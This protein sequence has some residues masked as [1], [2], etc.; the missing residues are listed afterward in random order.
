MKKLMS[1]LIA[2]LLI[3]GNNVT[4]FA[5]EDT[6]VD[7]NI[8]A[9]SNIKLSAEKAKFSVTVPISM[10]LLVKSEGNV[11]GGS[12][13]I[14]N[15]SA[16]PVKVTNVKVISQPGW[17]LVAGDADLRASYINSKKIG[18]KVNGANCDEN[19]DFKIEQINFPVINVDGTNE[20]NWG[21]IATSFEEIQ[22]E[23]TVATVVYTIGFAK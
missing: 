2:M 18:I 7:P 16:A 19:G 12:A 1:I 6:T 22:N 5:G 3:L 10:P 9:I 11:I 23:I 8:G 21:G 20:I 14:V 17:T 4:S 13:N 15:D